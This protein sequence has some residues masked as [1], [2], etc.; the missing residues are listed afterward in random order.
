MS[1]FAEDL[2][3]ILIVLIIAAI[4]G[5]L[6]SWFLRSRR[7]KSLEAEVD[8]LSRQKK[9]P[10]TQSRSTVQPQS[11]AQ[12]AEKVEP[13]AEEVESL[14]DASPTSV[15]EPIQPAFDAVAA[16]KA[17][18]KKIVVD[19]LT[20]IEGIGPKISGLLKNSGTHT[21][22]E[23]SQRSPAEIKKVLDDAGTAFQM[24]DPDTWP[25]QA[26]LAADGEWEALQQ[27]QDGLKGG[28]A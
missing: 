23:L 14:T 2:L 8:R 3:F 20:M 27:M 11:V 15:S 10:D 26:Q 12:T 21:W 18:G 1:R 6:L 5:F 24:H 17:L 25:K 28:R 4:L 7:I 9:Q 22:R 16:R 13:V 19:D